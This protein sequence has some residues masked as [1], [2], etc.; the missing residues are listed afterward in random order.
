MTAATDKKSGKAIDIRIGFMPLIDCAPVVVAALLGHAEREGLRLSLEREQSWAAVR[1]RI[2]IGHLDA[3]HMLAPMPIAA[4]LGLTPFSAPLV[5]PLSLGPAGNTVTVSGALASAMRDAGAPGDLDAAE[6]VRAMKRVVDE[7]AR[8]GLPQLKLAIVHGHS[9]HHYQLA[10]WLAAAGI[11]QERDVELVVVPPPRMP[12]ALADGLVDGFCV[13]EPW[14]SIAAADSGARIATTGTHIWR[15]SPEKVLGL[16]RDFAEARPDLVLK[17]VR[18]VHRAAEWCDR[19]ENKRELAELLARPDILGVPS[20]IVRRGLERRL[21]GLAGGD[22]EAPGFMTFASSAGTFPWVSHAAWLYAQMVRW[23]QVE[24]T[25][26]SYA[27]ACASYR[28]DLA[29]AALAPLGVP[30]PKADAKIEGALSAPTPIEATAG[31]LAIGPDGF[32]D[33]G[34]FDPD[35]IDGILAGYAVARR[36]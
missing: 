16:R 22:V 17:L 26:E 6:G 33:G 20:E 25:P 2:S 24:H 30:L 10:Y 36:A 21:V 12:S 11:V 27:A 8:Q 7:R 23:G 31:A 34:V 1:D 5:V 4:N 3:A 9:A 14:G 13:G 32:F 28:P 29:R 15:G 18:A 35:D 19:A